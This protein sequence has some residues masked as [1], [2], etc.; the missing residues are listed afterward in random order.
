MNLALRLRRALRPASVED[1]AAAYLG[2]ATSMSDLER[3]EREIDQG[4][5]RTRAF[6]R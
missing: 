2:E 4:R 5:F 3:R 6:P 1:R